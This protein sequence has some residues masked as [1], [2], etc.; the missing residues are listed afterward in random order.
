MQR[1]SLLKTAKLAGDNNSW[2]D[3][4]A[5]RNKAGNKLKYAKR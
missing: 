4:K 2:L 1:E 5:A 3:Y